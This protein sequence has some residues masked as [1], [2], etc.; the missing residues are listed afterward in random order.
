MKLFGVGEVMVRCVGELL[1][2]EVLVY[3]CR[4][5]VIG[6]I[7]FDEVMV[8]LC[9]IFKGDCY[10]YFEWFDGGLFIKEMVE[11]ACDLGYEYVVFIDYL[12]MFKVVCGLSAEWL[13][14]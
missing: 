1:V 10:I 5:E 13:E 12:F 11:V 3:L 4:F 9:V 6:E 7:L 2:G 14:W 8:V